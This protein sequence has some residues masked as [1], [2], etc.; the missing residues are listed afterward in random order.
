M[1]RTRP[2]GRFPT[3]V[4]AIVIVV[5]A[6]CL[7]Q[8][9][10]SAPKASSISIHWTTLTNPD[11]VVVEVQGLSK[12]TLEQLQQSRWELPQWQRLFTVFAGSPASPSSVPLPP[13]AG[14]YSIESET[15][16]FTPQFPLEPEVTYRAIFEP[17][18]LPGAG[19]AKADAIA[20]TFLLPPPDAT[21]GTV[22]T[23]VYPSADV[24]PENLLKFYIH[25]SAPMSRGDIYEH[26]QLLDSAGHEVELPFLELDEELWDPAMMRLT[27]IID[28][29]RIKRGVR[30]LED[31]GPVLETGKSYKLLISRRWKDA[32][33]NPLTET[34]EK[35]FKVGRP[36]RDP[37]N[38]EQWKVQAPKPDTLESLAV[39]FP[40]P[41]DHALTQRV[42]QVTGE[43]GDLIEGRVVLEEQEHHWTFI[44]DKPWRRGTY[45]LVIQ[46]T[47]ED[48]AGNNIGKPFD[49][50]TV[51]GGQKRPSAATV[52]LAFK[53]D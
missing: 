30:P 4:A 5:G 3:I 50:D 25:F 27:L 42:I 17:G 28:P 40:E 53:V 10:K 29:G 20:S 37:P 19:Q 34:F 32:N 8:A 33:R 51:E 35:T 43:S 47:I 13:M 14:A 31:I 18:H 49:V 36:D 45:Q 24:L 2:C 52:T 6:S 22:V 41:M 7:F 21:P 9:C 48:L 1:A 39:R 23:Q 46:T 16:R 44:P 11:K 38:P 12:A 15:L 26:I